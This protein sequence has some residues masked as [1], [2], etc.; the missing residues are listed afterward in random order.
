[1]LVVPAARGARLPAPAAGHRA[2]GRGRAH[3]RAA[4]PPRHP[5]RRRSRRDAARH[6]APRGRR[7]GGRAPV[8]AGRRPRP[9]AGAAATRSR[10]RSAPTAPSTPTSPRRPRS[11]ASC[12]AW[13]RR[14]A[15]GCAR[16][17]SS[18]ARSA[19]RSATPTS[20]PSPGCARCR[21]GRP[22]RAEIY[23]TAVEL[24][25]GLDLDRP[26]IRLVGVKCES[27]RDADDGRRAADPRPRPGR[28]PART[29]ADDAIDAARARFGVDAV[30]PGTLLGSRGAAAACRAAG[31][32][33]ARAA[34][35]IDHE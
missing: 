13:P 14:S 8:R 15:A 6:A 20:A 22:P 26:R 21:A 12:C 4:A 32:P 19:S 18:P 28:T 16:A 30:R 17:A 5:H 31:A 25:R 2:V 35:A 3:R 11:C 7:R 34:S 23:D 27:L 24:Y 10:S 9:A 1:M 33:D 29:R